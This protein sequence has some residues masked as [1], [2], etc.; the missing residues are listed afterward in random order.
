M[1]KFVSTTFGQISGKHGSAV[2]AVN[3]DGTNVLRVYNRPTNPNTP[4]QQEQRAKFGLVLRELGNF[5]EVIKQGHKNPNAVN[6]VMSYMLK[7]GITGVMPDFKLDFSMLKLAAGP[8]PG[9]SD[10][11]IT[12]D[13]AT[14]LVNMSWDTT[15]GVLGIAASEKDQL[16]I[17][18]YNELKKMCVLKSEVGERSIG[19]SSVDLPE[20]WLGDEVHIW[21][22]MSREDGSVNSDSTYIGLSQL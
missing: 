8:L 1:S 20:G 22:Y 2:A 15:I 13:A 21:A 12:P 18:V 5:R 7:N 11:V 17:V 16:N 14:T 6:R 4:K 10:V 19:T 3:R 9:V